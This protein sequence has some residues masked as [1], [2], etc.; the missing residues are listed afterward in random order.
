MERHKAEAIEGELKKLIRCRLDGVQ[1][2]DT[3]YRHRVAPLGERTTRCGC[4]AA[5]RT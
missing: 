2:F 5:G 4:T 1:V 3:L